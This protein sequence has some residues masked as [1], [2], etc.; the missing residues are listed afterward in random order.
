MR[1]EKSLRIVEPRAPGQLL[2]L[3]ESL[4]VGRLFLY[5]MVSWPLLNAEVV[6]QG[7]FAYL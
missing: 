4:L 1:T 6:A 7:A 2:F 3:A 5:V